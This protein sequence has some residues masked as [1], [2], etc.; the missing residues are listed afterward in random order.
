MALADK[1]AVVR[2]FAVGLG[3]ELGLPTQ[4]TGLGLVCRCDLAWVDVCTVPVCQVIDMR[5][6]C[7]FRT[8]CIAD[9][10]VPVGV[11]CVMQ[12]MCRVEL[13]MWH[14]A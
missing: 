9:M 5:D 1:A 10:A 14:S 13:G 11:A 6:T 7:S 2:Q 12:V 3:L 8:R 4:Q